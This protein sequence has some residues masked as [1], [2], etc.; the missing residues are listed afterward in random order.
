MGCDY[1]IEKNLHIHY[2]DDSLHV[3]NV[4]RDRGYYYDIKNDF[5]ESYNILEAL[6]QLKMT[7]KEKYYLRRKKMIKYHL[8]PRMIPYLIYYQ[9]E[10]NNDYLTN[11]YKK[12]VE[13]NWIDMNKEWSHVKKILMVE[14]RYEKE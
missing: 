7:E 9:N 6:S 12:I 14:K 3:V 1:Y 11:K 5:N 13:S 8:K 4:K 10:F 2:Y